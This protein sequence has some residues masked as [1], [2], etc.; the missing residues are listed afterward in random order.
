[1]PII[2]RFRVA[3]NRLA[4]KF[5]Q[6]PRPFILSGP[7]SSLALCREIAGT[8]VRR[9]MLVTDRPLFELGLVKPAIEVLSAAGITVETFCEVEPDPGYEVVLNG[10]ERL[11]RFGADAVLAIGGG[12]S[13]DC[14][15]AIVHCHAN[16]AHPSKLTGLWLYAP[17]RK[18]GLPLYAVPTTA[19]TGSE[20]TIVSVV[21]DKQ[22]KIK[23]P[24]IDPK[25]VPAM[26]ALDPQLMVG[27]PPHITA[28]TGMDA[29]TH[30]VEA[31]LSSLAEPETERLARAA[32][33]T[34]VSQLPR[35]HADGRDL[36]A[37]GRMAIASCMAGLAFTRAGVG[38][39]HAI[40][41]QL[42]ALY[43]IPHGL[44]NA[45]V[46]PHVLEFSK[47][48]CAHRL[49]DLARVSGLGRDGAS[50]AE[51]AD[52]FIVHVR[53]MNASM[54]IPAVVKELRSEDFDTIIRNAFAEAHGTYG[55]PRYMDEAEARALLGKL[56]P[57]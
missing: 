34:I 7:G 57:A 46:M 25:L 5:L 48:H 36:E 53:R 2:S 43:H 54:A 47:S 13:L 24:I 17:P 37:R 4:L 9:L 16:D 21:S 30:A 10:V 19:G 8:G 39:V 1:M 33:A 41:H 20:V 28:P 11:K 3:V 29:L 31:Y 55:V 12:S 38:Y 44:A 49:A 32:T 56:L 6:F 35:A 52:A 18:R 50:D 40:A 15:K 27:L 23:H 22:A 51:L 14:A 42:G 26:V 45:M